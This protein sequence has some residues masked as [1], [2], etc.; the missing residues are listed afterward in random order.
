MS[1]PTNI[2]ESSALS[3]RDRLRSLT[4]ARVG[5]GRTGVSQQTQD[6]LRF[7]ISHAQARDAVHHVAGQVGA[8]FKQYL[9]EKL[10]EHK[11][12]VRKR[13]EDMPEIRDWKWPY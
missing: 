9:R 7:Q 10:I 3:L 8:H 1:E 11:Q 6:V 5:L 4:P 13:G 12:Y 2:A